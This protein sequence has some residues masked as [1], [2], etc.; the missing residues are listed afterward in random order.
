M[1]YCDELERWSASG[2]WVGRVR[3]EKHLADPSVVEELPFGTPASDAVGEWR[4]SRDDPRWAAMR[5]F[6]DDFNARQDVS[7]E[8]I[9]EAHREH[10]TEEP[11]DLLVRFWLAQAVRDRKD[12]SLLSAL[13]AIYDAEPD[14]VIRSQILLGMCELAPTGD[15]ESLKF[16]EARSNSEK[17]FRASGTLEMVQRLIREGLDQP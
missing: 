6:F 10:L 7:N 8:S 9:V 14:A 1:C 12:T 4:S 15:P 11:N 3:Y 16:L 2:V 13:R 5:S 17:H